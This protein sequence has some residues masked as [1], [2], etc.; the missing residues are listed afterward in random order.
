MTHTAT[1][2]PSSRTSRIFSCTSGVLVYAYD[3]V[4]ACCFIREGNVVRVHSRDCVLVY[5]ISRLRNCQHTFDKGVGV[6]HHLQFGREIFKTSMQRE[7]KKLQ[8]HKAVQ[9]F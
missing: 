8:R 6:E 4:F 5:N 1:S 9:V 7:A 3:F 2:I